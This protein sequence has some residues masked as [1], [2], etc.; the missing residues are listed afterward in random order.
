MGRPEKLYAG[1]EAAVPQTR[2]AA[3]L[4]NSPEPA[5]RATWHAFARWQRTRKTLRTVRQS[6][7]RAWLIRF[8]TARKLEVDAAVFVQLRGS[9][10]VEITEGNLPATSAGQVVQDVPNDCVI[11]DLE[12]MTVPKHQH[13][14]RL[15]GG[16]RGFGLRNGCRG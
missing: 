4:P 13:S 12:L 16:R 9:G 2:C 11:C 1:E 10:K 6:A 14:R 3:H 15:I 8:N 7:A 5:A